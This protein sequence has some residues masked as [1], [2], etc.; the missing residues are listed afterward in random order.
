MEKIEK[1]EPPAT[2]YL[3]DERMFEHLKIFAVEFAVNKP[4]YFSDEKLNYN[5]WLQRPQTQE[6][7]AE[8]FP[9]P[10]YKPA[11]EVT[12][13]NTGEQFLYYRCWKLRQ[14]ENVSHDCGLY[15]RAS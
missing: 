5:E 12:P 4:N 14:D 6:L 9:N 10:W 1:K 11:N 8:L 15:R 2:K 7:L 13:T 3:I